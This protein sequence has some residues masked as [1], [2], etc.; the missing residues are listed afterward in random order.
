[1]EAALAADRRVRCAGLSGSGATMFALTASAA[2]AAALAMD[3]SRAYP[4]WWV[5]A[6]R[7]GAT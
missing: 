7:L 5:V 2:D 1:M 4:D 3:L 6:T